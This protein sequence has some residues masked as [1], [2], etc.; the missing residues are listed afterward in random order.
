MIFHWHCCPTVPSFTLYISIN[1]PKGDQASLEFIFKLVLRLAV[2]WLRF[3]FGFRLAIEWFPF[4]C[5]LTT[6]HSWE[7]QNIRSKI[8][9]DFLF[10]VDYRLATSDWMLS[11]LQFRAESE[12]AASVS[13]FSTLSVS[14]SFYLY[15]LWVCIGLCLWFRGGH[16]C[17]GLPDQWKHQK[18]CFFM[19]LV[20]FE[21]NKASFYFIFLF[22]FNQTWNSSQ[23]RSWLV[24]NIF[25]L[26]RVKLS[27]INPKNRSLCV[28]C[29]IQ[30]WDVI[31]FHTITSQLELV[32]IWI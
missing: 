15:F 4:W 29:L 26:G 22:V 9:D 6:G 11:D 12:D 3:S 1:G 24:W 16:N 7:I 2:E 18:S 28:I 13:V 21:P 25:G 14:L 19:F 30:V 23:K 27:R 31:A 10:A 5:C 8:K 20:V 32:C 17:L